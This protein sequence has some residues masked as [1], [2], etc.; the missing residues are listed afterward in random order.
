MSERY[1]NNSKSK[2]NKTGNNTSHEAAKRIIK[3]IFKKRKYETLD[4][5][6]ATLEVFW[7]LGDE[8]HKITLF[9]K[10]YYHQYDLWFRKKSDVS[11]AQTEIVIEVDGGYHNNAAQQNRDKRAEAF[12]NFFFPDTY[13]LRI[14]K[15]EIVQKNGKQI[16]ENLEI[17]KFINKKFQEKYK[18]KKFLL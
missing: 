12:M 8:D 4:F 13:F 18:V 14:N 5:S 15:L 6:E 10:D 7:N 3:D 17:E 1:Y 16:L 11:D 9:K 2:F